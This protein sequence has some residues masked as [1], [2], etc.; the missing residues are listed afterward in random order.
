[1]VLGRPAEVEDSAEDQL[2]I[3]KLGEL[4]PATPLQKD[5]ARLPKLTCVS[6]KGASAPQVEFCSI[7]TTFMLSFSL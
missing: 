6:L 7:N 2:I 4:P 5:L 1:M 3:C